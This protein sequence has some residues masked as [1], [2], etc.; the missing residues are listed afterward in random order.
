M[1]AVYGGMVW[2]LCMGGYDMME[3][4]VWDMV[5]VLCIGHGMGVWYGVLCMGYG[6]VWYGV[7]TVHD[8]FIYIERKH[9]LTLLISLTLP[10]YHTA[11]LRVFRMKV[12]YI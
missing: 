11:K 4:C 7:F 9:E 12:S 1:G 6:I 5:W 8:L 3:C 2:V 10:V